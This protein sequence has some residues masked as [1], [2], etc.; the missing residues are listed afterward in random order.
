M[1]LNRDPF[2]I[3]HPTPYPQYKDKQTRLS[4]PIII[5]AFNT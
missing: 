4:R 2:V 1:F 5:I 3:Q